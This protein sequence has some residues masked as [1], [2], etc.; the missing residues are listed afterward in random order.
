MDNWKKERP[1]V[2]AVQTSVYEKSRAIKATRWIAVSTLI[3]E[4]FPELRPS[5][6]LWRR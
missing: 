2:V 4:A 1:K 3:H 5:M 6:N